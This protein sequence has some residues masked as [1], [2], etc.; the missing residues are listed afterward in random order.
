[1]LALRRLKDDDAI[2]G[3]IT[4]FG[5][6]H[7]GVHQAVITHFAR[8]HSDNAARMRH[9]DETG[10]YTLDAGARLW[11]IKGLSAF[12]VDRLRVNVRLDQ[13]ARF[14]V[15]TFDLYSARSR[16]AFVDAAVKALRLDEGEEAVLA[17]EI[18]LVIAALERERLSL[19][20][21]KGELARADKQ[22]E[23]LSAERGARA[24]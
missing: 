10:V 1:M 9:L 20:Q 5:M 24:N 7:V 14:H 17:E 15:D 16:Q 13:G 2:A 23:I 3:V 4:V 18:A 12:G 21:G 11:R 22:V 6:P 19:R 8:P